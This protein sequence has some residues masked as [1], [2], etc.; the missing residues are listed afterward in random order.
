MGLPFNPPP[1]ATSGAA[2]PA[3]QLAG[4][5]GEGTD[6]IALAAGGCIRQLL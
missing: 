5:L 3:L 1:T 4:V 6:S 2:K